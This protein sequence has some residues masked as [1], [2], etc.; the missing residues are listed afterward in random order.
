[1]CVC[2]RMYVCMYACMYLFVSIFAD[3]PPKHIC[4]EQLTSFAHLRSGQLFPIATLAVV[5]PSQICAVHLFLEYQ[6][7]M[8][9]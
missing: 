1:M 3:R 9:V 8:A 2:A 4:P 5:P 6:M 7:I